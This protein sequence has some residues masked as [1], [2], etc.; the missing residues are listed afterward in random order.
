MYVRASHSSKQ[1]TEP[2]VAA[3][4]VTAD[5]K[6]IRDNVCLLLYWIGSPC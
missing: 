4:I 6:Q 1:H 2:W 5:G 3:D